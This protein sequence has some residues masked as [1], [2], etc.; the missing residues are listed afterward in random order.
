MSNWGFEDENTGQANTNEMN[1][2]KALRDAYEAQKLKNKELE[3]SLA[4]IRT[5][6]TQQKVS[7]TL[8]EL[9]LPSAA[10]E[11]Y[12]GEADPEKVREWATTM[13]SIFGGG[14][15]NPGTPNPTDQAAQPTLDA[16]TQQQL[17]RMTE[18]GQSG[19]PLGNME[20]AQAA[21]GDANDVNALLAAWRNV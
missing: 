19:T 6:L 2:P 11:Q 10:A 15:E 20:A 21:V 13:K 4:S 18:A 3:D 17:Q 16:S 1:G 8:S 5:E 7:S 9:G 12:K 14:Q